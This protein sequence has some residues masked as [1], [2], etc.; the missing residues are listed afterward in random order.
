MTKQIFHVDMNSF[1]ASCEQVRNS[2]L[3]NQP[4]I[5]GGDPKTRKGIV[6]AASYEAKAQGIYTTMPLWQALK[7]CP[8]AIIVKADHNYYK[9]ISHQVM[10]LLDQYTPLKEQMSIDEACLDM[11]GCDEIFGQP[12]EI[13]AMIQNQ[14]KE[15]IG[16]PCSIGISSNKILAKMASDMKKPLGITFLYPQVIPQKLWPLSVGKLHGVGE[17]QKQLLEKEGIFT[18]GSLA[19]YPLKRLSQILG[20]KT[21]LM[22]HQYANGIDERPVIP[23]DPQDVKSISNEKTFSQ[24]L[25]NQEKIKKEI[26]LLA[27]KV[28]WRLRQTK[29]Q[30]KT[31]F[32]KIKYYNFLTVTRNITLP[33]STDVTDVLYQQAWGLFLKNWN[34]KPIRLLGVGVTNL[35]TLS[36]E[37]ISLWASA[38]ETL[39]KKKKID[40]AIDHLRE[41]YGYDVLQR[42]ATIQG[43][44]CENE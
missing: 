35:D 40:H 19:K 37:Q 27:E 33:M 28:G 1:Y 42:A 12:K 38:N 32:I 31:I 21:A 15:E 10:D 44:S 14:I 22:M 30:G 43:N 2:T 3:R 23:T 24:D 20:N 5:V 25:V 36:Y 11:T 6:L 4:I 16:I 9:E 26:L 17:K 41:K 8:Q 13:A 29:V 34:Q 7:K 39:E 18:I